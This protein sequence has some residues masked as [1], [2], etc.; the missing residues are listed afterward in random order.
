MTKDDYI[1]L[2]F[3]EPNCRYLLN[4]DWS[5]FKNTTNKIIITNKDKMIDKMIENY[6][7]IYNEIKKKHSNLYIITPTT[8][9][10]P[11]YNYLTPFNKKLKNIFGEK[12]LD[13]YSKTFSIDIY[14]QDKY[15][16]T[17][18]KKRTRYRYKI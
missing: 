10:Y 5:V 13:I 11:T 15:L 16:S 6:M 4:K 3:G 1:Y 9:Y 17:I 2:N 12:V 18:V 8:A 7:V 14:S